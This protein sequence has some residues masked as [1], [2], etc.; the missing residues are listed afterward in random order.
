[1]LDKMLKD[2]ADKYNVSV[3]NLPEDVKAQAIDTFIR[4]G[5][6]SVRGIR[7]G[8]IQGRV[9]DI[10]T[11][12]GV[13][14]DMV[15]FYEDPI[16]SI[17]SYI[18]TMN[19]SIARQ[20]LFGKGVDVDNFNNESS[21]GAYVA[22]LLEAG[23]IDR[24][25]Q[26]EIKDIFRARFAKDSNGFFANSLQKLRSITYM[27]TLVDIFTT[28]MQVG[29]LLT[30][31]V[32]RG[33]GNP[34][35]FTKSLSKA[36]LGQIP[37]INR[38]IKSPIDAREY[39]L[40]KISAEYTNKADPYSKLLNQLFR[41]SGFSALDRIG[42]ETLVNTVIEKARKEARKGKFSKNTQLLID[43][44][45]GKDSDRAKD[46]VDELKSTAPPSEDIISLAYW[47]LLEHQPVAESEMPA[48][49]LK[50]PGARMAYQLKTWQLKQLSLWRS[51]T[52]G[53][54]KK[55]QK[56]QA[57]K[58]SVL[59][60]TLLVAA[61]AGPDTLRDYLQGRPIHLKDFMVDNIFRL[62][63]IS[64]YGAR[65]AAKG[66]IAG[67]LGGFFPAVGT[68][69]TP[70]QDI[71]YINDWLKYSR[72]PIRYRAE[73]GRKKPVDSG[74]YGVS[75]LRMVPLVGKPFY[76]GLAYPSVPKSMSELKDLATGVPKRINKN[77]KINPKVAERN[78]FLVEG[79]RGRKQILKRQ[80]TYYDNLLKQ[81]TV[82]NLKRPANKQIPWPD[83]AIS[84]RTQASLELANIKMQENL[85]NGW[86]INT[87][88]KI[89]EAMPVDPF[90]IPTFTVRD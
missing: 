70:I 59:M 81:I 6:S 34:I 61:G 63:G 5:G 37:G 35:I 83:N 46:I 31:A 7:P 90:S 14:D 24:K 25:D 23:Q 49:Y 26:A 13:T 47:T 32:Y 72:D 67:F 66:D 30:G 52:I 56:V 33:V 57:I 58:N 45:F 20:K 84:F 15:G 44:A 28:M 69:G 40:I 8:F 87:M 12:D 42:K 65:K 36:I 88:K 19:E 78:Y 38:M 62:F 86:W 75:S 73:T 10:K 18:H 76:Y 9:V 11:E 79:W 21:V 64:R 4:T 55:G 27:T 74:M 17:M 54:W 1:M 71:A 80:H 53:M 22:G 68:I 41:A 77:T 3:V 85:E 60:T 39:G 89:E 82:K 29:D 51:E 16:T 43:D 50:S 48:L 2:L